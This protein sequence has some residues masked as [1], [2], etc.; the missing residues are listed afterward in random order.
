M[1]AS[2]RLLPA[3]QRGERSLWAGQLANRER[4]RIVAQGSLQLSGTDLAEAFTVVGGEGSGVLN[5][6]QGAVL[7]NEITFIAAG[8]GSSGVANVDGA[9]SRIVSSG[10]RISVGN[11]GS[12]TLNITTGG[13]VSGGFGLIG[14]AFGSTGSVSVDG[15]GSKWLNSNRLSWETPG[16]VHL[17]SRTAALW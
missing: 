14:D 10:D 2:L 17:R 12:G 13:L 11:S 7:T 5:I 4:C 16:L 9:G 8:S 15:A 1:V 6:K 3:E